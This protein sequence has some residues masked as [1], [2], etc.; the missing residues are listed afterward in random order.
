MS[1]MACFCFQAFCLNIQKP[2]GKKRT[3]VSNGINAPSRIL[4]CYG[5]I[6]TTESKSV[7]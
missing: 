2:F 4:D 5:R 1:S 3:G 6:A 7:F